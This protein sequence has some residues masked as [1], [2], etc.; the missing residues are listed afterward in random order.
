MS[1]AVLLPMLNTISLT[2]AVK[3]RPWPGV[4]AV[5]AGGE[6]IIQV[7]AA[8]GFSQCVHQWPQGQG[9]TGPVQTDAVVLLGGEGQGKHHADLPGQALRGKSSVGIGLVG[10]S[11]DHCRYLGVGPI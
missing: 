4:Q 8:P 7:M 10:V 9:T 1:A 3:R 2:V 6:D 11:I 5:L